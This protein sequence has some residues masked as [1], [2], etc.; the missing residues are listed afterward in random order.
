MNDSKMLVGSLSNDLMRVA[1]LKARG[2]DTAAER[3][4]VEAKRWAEELEQ[5]QHI[6]P[7]IRKIAERVRDSDR[8]ITEENAERYLMFGVL[9]QNY[10]LHLEELITS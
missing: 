2:A 7:Y 10:A 1:A 9:L 5:D 4:L 3:F 8:L 6:K